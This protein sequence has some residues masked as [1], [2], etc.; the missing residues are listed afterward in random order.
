MWSQYQASIGWRL[1]AMLAPTVIAG[2]WIGLEAR[3]GLTENASGL[4]EAAQIKQMV[5]ESFGQV[6]IQDEA[7]KTMVLFPDDTT[8]MSR[9]IKAFDANAALLTTLAK[10]VNRPGLR[11]MIRHLRSIAD[12]RLAPADTELSEAAAG[13]NLAQAGKIYRTRFL[14]ARQEYEQTVLRAALEAERLAGTAQAEMDRRNR[15]SL[16][17]IV[18]SLVLGIGTAGAGLVLLFRN[19]IVKPL[20]GASEAMAAVAG[21][22]LSRKVQVTSRH[23]IGR[24]GE[25]VNAMVES[26]RDSMLG[27]ARSSAEVAGQAAALHQVSQALEDGSERASAQAAEA[28]KAGEGM[29]ASVQQSSGLL[30]T[31]A[32]SIT[33]VSEETAQAAVLAGNAVRM[34]HQT[35]ESVERL[36]ESGKVID[37]ITEAMNRVA[38][39]TN[40]LAL[41]AAIEAARQGEAGRGFA[42]VAK[43]IRAMAE[44][45]QE[46]TG[47]ISRRVETVRTGIAASVSGIAAIDESILRLATIAA[48]IAAETK[49]QGNASA[50]LESEAG[51]MVR[52]TDGISSHLESVVQVMEQTREGAHRTRASAQA[53]AASVRELDQLLAQFQS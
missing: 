4:I 48:S 40:I 31:L 13:G 9:K 24:V 14:P 12:H 41:N 52:S 20:A 8:A 22:D 17:T 43:Q 23:E 10:R 32:T 37:S 34:T 51:A 38:F 46:A 39:E 36:A 28:S 42:V 49:R 45:T 2:I 3:A 27:A 30:A 25:A 47:E 29:K 35:R 33:R 44:Q 15:A 11:A 1:Y 26:V 50:Q 53:V 6:L 19:S 21:G 7:S 16:R 5:T 18:L